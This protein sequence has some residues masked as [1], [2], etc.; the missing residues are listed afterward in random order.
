MLLN[1]PLSKL[2]VVMVGL[3]AVLT[4]MYITHQ[5]CLEGQN[6]YG[7]QDCPVFNLAW[8]SFKDL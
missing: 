6:V 1:P 3:P 2:V 7:T 4:I 8:T 5:Y